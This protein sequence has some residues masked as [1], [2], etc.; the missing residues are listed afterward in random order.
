MYKYLKIYMYK[1]LK[2]YIYYTHTR[3]HPLLME[4]LSEVQFSALPRF[5]GCSCIGLLLLDNRISCKCL[6]TSS[7][8]THVCC[9]KTLKL[10]ILYVKFESHWLT[11]ESPA[12]GP[13][14]PESH[15]M[16]RDCLS[17]HMTSSGS[18]TS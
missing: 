9:H 8:S 2:K 5:F 12:I 4:L 11:S 1:Y 14:F 13:G 3:V 18:V 6:Y 7:K 16:L 17:V 10:P 15:S